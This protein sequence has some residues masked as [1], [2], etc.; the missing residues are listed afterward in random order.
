MRLRGLKSSQ[1]PLLPEVD[2]YLHLLVLLHL[3][4]ESPKNAL[5]CADQLM[6]KVVLQ[7][8]RSFDPLA[9]RCYYYL[10]RCYEKND[11]VEK[12][13]GLLHSRLRTTTLRND[14]EGQAVLINCLLRTYIADNLYDQVR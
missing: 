12:I 10:T 6:S 1:T 8:R 14:Y 13:R 11:C 4:D 9:A 3:L 5:D 2:A 7:H